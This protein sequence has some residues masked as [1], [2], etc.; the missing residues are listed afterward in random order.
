MKQPKRSCKFDNTCKL[1]ELDKE[2][3]PTLKKAQEKDK[4]G[5]KRDKN[6]KHESSGIEIFHMSLDDDASCE[7]SQGDIKSKAFINSEIG[8]L[9]LNKEK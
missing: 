2:I 3:T 7:H 5:S 4:I 1:R 8:Q 6:G 9:A